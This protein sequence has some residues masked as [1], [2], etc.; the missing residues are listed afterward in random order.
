MREKLR[1]GI[2][3]ATGTVGQRFVESLA[4]HPWFELTALTAS[5]AS[6]GRKYADACRWLLSSDIPASVA[7]MV[8]RE[9]APTI[10]CDVVFSALPGD[11]AGPV[12]EAFAAAGYGVFSN[13][14]AHRRDPDVPLLI[15]EVNPDHL[16]LVATQQARRGWKRGFIVTNPNC[17][18]VMLTVALAPLH[19]TF[20]LRSVLVSTMQGLSGAGYPGVPSLDALDNVIPFIGG[21][22][23]KLSF[24]PRK[25]LGKVNGG[26]IESADFPISAH[27]N[28]VPAREGHLETV[29]IALQRSATPQE[30]IDAWRDWRPLPQQLGLPTA[31]QPP[32]VVRPEPDRPQT[33][34]DRDA[35]QGMAVSVGRVR[36]CDVLDIK[37][38]ALGH[39]TIR[40][41]AGA[42][43]LNAELMLAQ[44]MLKT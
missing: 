41:A 19:A 25:M 12:E 44:G 4:G 5:E 7:D 11:Q 34:L 1:V 35:G 6:A 20:G 43:V 32:I 42:S 39:N 31:P 26:E 22:E 30:I 2:L 9:T 3:G 23:E 16:S 38:I 17:S 28:R 10:D 18:A 29:S 15:P 40:G 36:A 14:S 13:V 8:V 27:C 37:F 24:E 21:E 33:R